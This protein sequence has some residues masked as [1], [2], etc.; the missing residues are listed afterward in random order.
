MSITVLKNATLSDGSRADITIEGQMVTAIGSSMAPGIDCSGLIAMPAFVDVHTHLREPGL[1]ASETVLSG[2]KSAAAGGY[3]AVMAM[4]NTSPVADNANVVEKVASLGLDA[5][6]AF[7]QPIGAVTLG[8][9]GAE[10]SGIVAMNQSRAK[11]TMFSDDGNCVFDPSLMRSALLE[12]KRFDGVIA[13][14]A[15]DPTLTQGSQMN[16]GALATELGLKGWPAIAEEAI[17]ERD[18]KMAEETGARLH[19]CHLTTAGAVEVVRWAKKRGVRI[20]AEVTP[21]HLLL[22]EELV[23][24]YDPVYKVNPPL[25]KTEDTLAL[26]AA[27]LDGTIDVIGTDHAPHSSEKKQCEWQNAAFGMVGLEHAASVLQEVLIEEGGRDWAQF[28]S[29]MSTKPAEIGSLAHFGSLAV[30]SRA[31][32]TL[33]DPSAKRAILSQTHSKS[34]NNPFSGITLP[35]AIEHTI[36]NGVF[37]YRNR[38]IEE[39]K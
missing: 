10:L 9:A 5:G 30:G 20:T 39:L 6:Y 19:I 22:T 28:A 24:S 11:V 14:H 8:L 4:A 33:L 29:L 25:R 18:A 36:F 17:I 12:V 7:V 13:Q 35:G 21:H 27:V 34:S 32:I 38:K 3:G 15:Q 16:A 2:T 37:T 26:R 31:N 1:E 23:R